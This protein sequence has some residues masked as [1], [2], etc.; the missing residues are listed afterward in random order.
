MYNETRGLVNKA[1]RC[2]RI[3]MNVRELTEDEYWETFSSPMAN[4]TDSAE[5]IVDLW[6]Y[7]DPIIE[8][9]YLNCT[10]WDWRVNHI[11]ETPD[12]VFQHIG[13]AVPKDDTYLVVIIDKPKR[14]I[15]GHRIIDL[16]AMYPGR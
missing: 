5:E 2:E 15:I 12:G 1:V 16:A 7:A 10:A 8:S 6:E 11:Y 9:E 4:V 14:E 13:I 3:N